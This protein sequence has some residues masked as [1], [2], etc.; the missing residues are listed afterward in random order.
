MV[1]TS[2][3]LDNST[4]FSFKRLLEE[5]RVDADTLY[6]AATF[7]EC[8]VTADEIVTSPTLAWTPDSSDQL[9]QPGAPCRSIAPS[10]FDDRTLS[11]IFSDAIRG[12]ISDLAEPSLRRFVNTDATTIQRARKSMQA[13]AADAQRDS[14]EFMNVYSGAVYLTDPASKATVSRLKTGVV[15]ADAPARHLAQ[16]LLRTNVAMELAASSK[17]IVTPY[18]PHSYRASFV[19]AKLTATARNSHSLALAI[20]QDFEASIQDL[21]TTLAQSPLAKFGAFTSLGDDAP[22]VLAVALSGARTPDDVLKAALTIRNSRQALRYRR[23]VREMFVAIRSRH[24]KNQVEAN[25]ELLAAREVLAAE[26]KRLYGFTRTDIV[27]ATTAVARAI[28]LEALATFD[29]SKLTRKAL[30]EV[31]KGMPATRSWLDRRVLKHKVA[32]LSQLTKQGSSEKRLND[33]LWR[34]FRMKLSSADLQRFKELREQQL[35]SACTVF[36]RQQQ[37]TG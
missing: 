8:L 14:R 12:S 16:F 13:W 3:L 17:G 29:V 26:L 18:H 7:L 31:V 32:L 30:T 34:A 21:K 6:N 4:Y 9:F 11:L 1:A 22:L 10:A 19:I 15:A 33:L 25:A 20:L 5:R 2:I 23:W 37:S 27:G 28:D 36:G 35:R 24:L